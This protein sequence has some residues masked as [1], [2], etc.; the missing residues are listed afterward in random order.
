MS[1]IET[2]L[3]T[4]ALWGIENTFYVRPETPKES[5]ERASNTWAMR[6]LDFGL[7]GNDAAAEACAGAADACAVCAK[8][9]DTIDSL[10]RIAANQFGVT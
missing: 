8:F 2:E 4:S 10:G 5:W 7:E 1:E 9:L 3:T 6:A